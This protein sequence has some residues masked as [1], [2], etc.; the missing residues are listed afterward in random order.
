V[1]D[2]SVSIPMTLS[3]L[4]G[5]TRRVELFLRISVIMHQPSDLQNNFA[6]I[7]LVRDGRVSGGGDRH[8]PSQGASSHKFL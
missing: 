1:A 3:D 6:V 4:K 8:A 5:G 7:T 2:Q